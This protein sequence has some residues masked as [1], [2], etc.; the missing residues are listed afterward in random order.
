MT[1][2]NPLPIVKDIEKFNC[3]YPAVAISASLLMSHVPG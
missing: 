1:F 2:V 3:F